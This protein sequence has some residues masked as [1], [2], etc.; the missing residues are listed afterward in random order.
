MKIEIF[1]KKNCHKCKILKRIFTEE[2]IEFE[3]VAIHQYPTWAEDLKDRGF[4]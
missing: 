3:E 2:N 4:T 1:T